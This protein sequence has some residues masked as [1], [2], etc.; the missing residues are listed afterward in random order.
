M[1]GSSVALV[2][3]QL[4]NGRSPWES[5]SRDMHHA[6]MASAADVFETDDERL[7]DDLCRVPDL[8]F[9][10]RTLPELVARFRG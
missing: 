10:V 1:V 7:R 3:A 5:D 9:E 6:V 2:Y 8:P 4:V